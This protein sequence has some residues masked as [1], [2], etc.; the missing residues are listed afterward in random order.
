[1]ATIRPLVFSNIP[2]IQQMD[3]RSFHRDNWRSPENIANLYAADPEG[4]YI[5]QADEKPVGYIFC[6]TFGS[7]GYFG[8]LGVDP[9]EQNKGYGKQLIGVGL[10]YLRKHC[11]VIGL[12][13]MPEWGKNIG[14]YHSMGFRSLQPA[15]I[16]EKKLSS[17][18]RPTKSFIVLRS[19]AQ[20]GARDLSRVIQAVGEWTIRIYP[21]LDINKDLLLFLGKY[22]QQIVFV[23]IG[24]HPAGFIAF[25]P[26]FNC[27]PWGMVEPGPD[28]SEVFRGLLRGLEGIYRSAIQMPTPTTAP[29]LRFH[30][31][32]R[33][34]TGL[35]LDEGYRLVRDT[36]LM[37]LE[38]YQDRYPSFSDMLLLRAWIG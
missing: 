5:C 38:D 21:G 28:D 35:L 18:L 19:G 22:P 36:E 24:N 20:L 37:V 12:E 4:C 13:T 3:Q 11:R 16:M 33:R 26:D 1:M 9:D 14:L 30:T 7:I 15:R 34:L 32:F 10:D 23:L 25:H 31:R 17:D 29:T 8:P 27:Y 6:R 2:V